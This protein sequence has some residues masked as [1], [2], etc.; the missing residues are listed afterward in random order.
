[1]IVI[2]ECSP[3]LVTVTSGYN[4]AWKLPYLI[5]CPSY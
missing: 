4:N 3:I 1:V 5:L 2:T